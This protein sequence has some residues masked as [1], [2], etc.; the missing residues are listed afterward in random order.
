M[1]DKAGPRAEPV[2][3]LAGQ[4]T[5][6]S[7]LA[8]NRGAFDAALDCFTQADRNGFRYVLGQEG[9]LDQC[10]QVCEWLRPKLCV[11][12]CLALCGPPGRPVAGQPPFGR[13]AEV[14]TSL[15]ADEPLFE[16]LVHAVWRRDAGDFRTLVHEA[17]IDDVCQYVCAWLCTVLLE[18]ACAIMCSEVL[19][20]APGPVEAAAAAAAQLS[21]LHEDEA[22]MDAAAEAVLAR[23]CDRLRRV[24]SDAGLRSDGSVIS[25]WLCT[26]HCTWLGMVLCG[27]APATANPVDVRGEVFGF[28]KAVGPLQADSDSLARLVQAVRSGSA[29]QFAGLAREL[30]LEQHCVQLCRWICARLCAEFRA[31]AC[32]ATSSAFFT[33]IGAY[34]YD[35]D[36]ASAIG[37]NGLTS[38]SRAFYDT[39][40]LNGGFCVVTGAPA[41]QYRFETVLTDAVG[42]PTCDWK[43][44]RPSQI[45]A[46]NIGSFVRVAPPFTFP[47]QVWVNGDPGP[48]VSVI[49]PD[50]DG[51][52]QVPVCEPSPGWQFVPGSDLVNLITTTLQ[53]FPSADE[54]D[55]VAG[56]SATA[57]TP[58]D[59]YYGIRMRVRDAGTGSAG[60]DAGTCAHVAFANTLYDFV[61]HHQYWDGYV[62]SEELAVY[63]LGV[64][65]LAEAGCAGLTDA[66]TV[67]FTA[68]H[69][70][71]DPAGVGVALIGPGGP[72]QFSLVPAAPPLPGDWHGQ[73]IPEGWTLDSL[74]PCAYILELTVNVR[75]TTGDA[76]PSPRYD[77]IAFWKSP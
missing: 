70:N 76:V 21:R 74:Q 57:P 58:A 22:A 43:P 8:G 33:R 27:V 34:Y 36:V 53:P 5:A 10:E 65:E 49:T 14:I 68:S 59:V 67:L 37:G 45:A 19:V 30:Q 29:E 16:E 3:E 20:E 31:C 38:D 35:L 69:P 6:I 62:G 7:A 42:N 39:I 55:V 52:I 56:A 72:Y 63:S 32:P 26:V 44:V 11:L 24:I 47:V 71:L 50:P 77:Q 75:L 28:A 54:R 64:T 2:T 60:T 23:D 12:T 15:A 25:Q 73:A 17:E 48:Q 46:T 1:C 9:L 13:I 18:R 41:I 66:L 51:W 61:S 4:A 40:R